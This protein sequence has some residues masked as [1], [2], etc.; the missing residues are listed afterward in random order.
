MTDLRRLPGQLLALL[1]AV[2]LLLALSPR[3]AQGIPVFSRR[4]KVSCQLCHEPFPKLTAFGEQFAANGFRMEPRQEQPD[5]IGTNDSLLALPATIP[6]AVRVDGYVQAYAK[7]SAVTDFQAPYLVKLLSSATLGKT[8]SYYFYALLLESGEPG[9]VEDAFL[10][11]N[12]IGGEPVDAWLGQ[13]QVSDA[14]FSRELRLEFEDYVVY[15]TLVGAVPYDLTYDRGLGVTAEYG[16]FGLVG[17]LV[18]GNGIGA[19]QADAH[20][21]VDA[22]KNVAAHLRH[23]LGRVGGIGGL[24]YYGQ[25]VG[26]GQTNSTTMLGVDATF[27]AGIFQ[28]NGQF[29]YRFDSDP[30]FTGGG[31]A[32]ATNGGFGELIIRPARSRWYGYGLYNLVQANQ[33]VLDVG[34]GLPPGLGRYES[35]AAGTGYLVR[36][37]FRLTGETGYDLVQDAFRLTLGFSLAY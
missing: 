11:A 30:L 18:N 21:D 9:G 3:T 10:Y 32:V 4:Y 1:P 2:L 6:L 17:D 16:G 22:K 28:F 25:A 29:L 33:P 36:R 7:G 24:Y 31:P 5:T 35:V 20:F 13:F 19:A 37:N 27:A 34:L 15:R 26:N 14:M 8:F 23:G 12:D